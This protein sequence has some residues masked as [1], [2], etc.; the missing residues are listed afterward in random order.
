MINAIQQLDHIG[1]I[2]EDAFF[3][4]LV[5]VR[6]MDIHLCKLDSVVN[7]TPVCNITQDALLVSVIM[8]CAAIVLMAEA[9]QGLI[10]LAADLAIR[11]STI[12]L[13]YPLFVGLD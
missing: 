4:V 3:I 13:G 9:A 5:V 11:E 7:H 1:E 10:F 6:E 2:A 8:V 12:D